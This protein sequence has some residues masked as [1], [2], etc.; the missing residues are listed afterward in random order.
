MGVTS[1][2]GRRV[3]ARPP[4]GQ[5]RLPTTVLARPRKPRSRWEPGVPLYPVPVRDPE[6][7]EEMAW[8]GFRR[9]EEQDGDAAVWEAPTS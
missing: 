4:A 7:E 2:R 8:W 6:R 9:A 1:F 5:M 3:V